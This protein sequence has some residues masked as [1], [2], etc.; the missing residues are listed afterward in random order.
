MARSDI[1]KWIS[2]EAEAFV[3]PATPSGAS[4]DSD[5]GR[6]RLT[7]SRSMRQFVHVAV[8]GFIGALASG[9]LVFLV[10]AM[11]DPV[12]PSPAVDAKSPWST[13]GTLVRGGKVLGHPVE[14]VMPLAAS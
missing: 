14:E 1:N 8:A 11:R 9:A 5:P 6:K 4:V 10:V 3:D 12:E 7:G 2:G 13:S